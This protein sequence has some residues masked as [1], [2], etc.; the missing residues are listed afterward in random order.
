MSA[1]GQVRVFADYEGDVSEV[2]DVVVV[3]SGPSGAVVAKELTDAGKRVVLV[4]EGPPFTPR[5]F[6]LDGAIS[7]ARTMREGGLRTTRGSV[8]STMQA[9]CLGGGSLV[10]SAICVRAPD[11]VL[12]RWCG[13]FD[14]SHTTRVD[15]DPHYDAVGSF[16]GISPTPENVLGRRNLL[17]RDG[18]EALGYDLWDLDDRPFDS[19]PAASAFFPSPFEEAAILTLDGVGE[20]ATGSIGLGRGNRIEALK[21]LRFPHS[22]GLL[23]SAFTYFT[24]FKVNSGEYKLMGL[25]P[26]GEPLYRDRILEELLDLKED[27][28]FRMNLDYFAYTHRDVMTSARMDRLF[29]GPPRSAESAASAASPCSTAGA[30]SGVFSMAA[31]IALTRPSWPAPGSPAPASGGMI[32]SRTHASAPACSSLKIASWLISVPVS[33]LQSKRLAR[34]RLIVSAMWRASA[35][36]VLVGFTP[37]AVT[38]MLPSMMKRLRTS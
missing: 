22:L 33:C 3:G 6:E 29:D 13:D 19:H 31:S 37:P 24:G 20:W 16:L 35:W 28:S 38:K 15:L 32:S 17:F 34:L 14:L 10:N 18:C 21:E 9:I 1:P 12:D 7:M 30:R 5:E 2:A 11:F 23:Y 4:E 8:I 26:Y 27:G 25:A 36:I